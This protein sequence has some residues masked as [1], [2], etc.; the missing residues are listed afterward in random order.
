MKSKYTL[1][2]L[3]EKAK[4]DA[5]KVPVSEVKSLVESGRTSPL[6]VKH[7]FGPRRI[8]QMFNPLKIL[9][10]I[11]TIVIITAALLTWNAEN[12]M[13]AYLRPA[14]RQK[15]EDRRDAYLRPADSKQTSDILKPIADEPKSLGGP[16]INA[17][18]P[19]GLEPKDTVFEGVIL[20]L[21]KE[22]LTR[23][24]FMFDD[25]GY[26]YLNK[27]PD[28][29]KMN[30]WSYYSKPTSTP[31]GS[32]GL[33][34]IQSEGGS[35]GFASGGFVNKTNKSPLHDFDFYPV[36]TTNLIGEDLNPI[37]QIAAEAKESFE[38]MNDTLVPILFSHSKLGG[39]DTEDKLVWFKVSD[40][41]FDLLKTEQSGKARQIYTTSKDLSHN[42]I[43]TNR[44]VFD[45]T[46]YFPQPLTVKLKPQVLECFG[47]VMSKNRV[48]YTFTDYGSKMQWWVD[49]SE[50]GVNNYAVSGPDS[51]ITI[52]Q[53]DEGI[54]LIIDDGTLSADGKKQMGKSPV[55][56]AISR[57]YHGNSVGLGSYLRDLDLMVPVQIDDPEAS[58]FLKEL[59]IWIYPNERFF[60]CLPTDISGQMRKE[61]N[62]QAKKLDPNFVP[63]MGGSVGIGGEKLKKDSVNESIEPVPCV[64]FTNLCESLPGLDYI[65][66]YPNP[67]TDMLSVDLVL[68]KAK[69][70]RFRVIDLG[71]RVI[72]DEGAPKD[73][74][75][76]GRFTHQM[77]VSKLQ[78]GFYLLVMT[79]E[80][81]AKVTRRFVKN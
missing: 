30:C 34:W 19:S 74:P 59:I 46:D 54:P 24:G 44:V 8:M 64:Y 4:L 75:V 22:E 81:G 28:G 43:P 68:Q 56:F 67:A 40:Q 61:F 76:G 2:E 11:T 45:Y 18:K 16:V 32:N 13:D 47:I 57:K 72:S 17:Q 25:E 26:Y 80:D 58:D 6:A 35:F 63:Q 15:T 5:K 31:S 78:N 79:D 60:N 52:V 29:S 55:I 42:S 73:F 23:L 14:E 1:S 39:Y 33:V 50:L 65:N 9:I 62:Y 48:E 71:G 21:T 38:L 49:A 20:D 70:I 51:K 41:F 12:R 7:S 10:M 77:D 53:T 36:L 69:K 37:E 66:L 3:F 27:L